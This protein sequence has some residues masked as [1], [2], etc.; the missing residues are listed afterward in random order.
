VPANRLSIPGCRRIRL[1][2]LI[3]LQV[4]F[5]ADLLVISP[6]SLRLIKREMRRKSSSGM[7]R[8][9]SVLAVFFSE[10]SSR[11]QQAHSSQ[12]QCKLPEIGF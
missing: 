9:K 2:S 5:F 6:N 12:K 7:A 10:L 1:I 3:P 8:E 11:I 4:F